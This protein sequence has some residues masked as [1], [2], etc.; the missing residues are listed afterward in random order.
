MKRFPL[1]TAMLGLTVLLTACPQPA[2]PEAT[3]SLSVVLS[4][5][6]NAPVRITNTTSG[7]V[8]FDGAL[9]SGKN[10]TGLAKGAVLKVDPGSVNGFTT[11]AAQTVTLDASKTVTLDYKALAGTAVQQNRIQGAVSDLP[12]GSAISVLSQGSEV[13]T[14]NQSAV[15]GGALGLSLS[16]APSVPLGPLMPTGTTGYCRFTGTGSVN[17]NVALFS[18][19]SLLSSKLDYLGTVTETLVA[20]GTVSG[21]QVA[22]LYSDRAATVQGTVNCQFPDGVTLKVDI[23]LTLTAGWNAVEYA[24]GQEQLTLRT[25]GSGARSVLKATRSPGEVSVSLAGPVE[26]TSDAD[27]AVA[28]SIYQDGGYTGQISLSTDVPGLTIEPGTVTLTAATLSSQGV[29][30]AAYLRHLGLHPQRLDTTLTFRY[31]GESNLNLAPFQ[32]VARDTAGKQVGNGYGTVS[33]TRPGLSVMLCPPN[34]QMFPSGTLELSVCASSVG[35]YTGAVTYTVAGLPAGLSAAPV[36]TTLNGASYVTL[37][38]TGDGTVKPGTYPITVTGTSADKSASAAGE[39]TVRAPTVNLS[40]SGYEFSVSQGETAS[41]PVMVSTSNGFSGPTTVT[42]TDLPAGVTTTPKTVTVTPGGSTQVM[43]PVQASASAALG[44]TT[45]KVTSPNLDPFTSPTATLSVRPA[46]AALPVQGPVRRLAQASSGAWITTDGA[47]DSATGQY[48]YQVTR[49]SAS[50]QALTSASAPGSTSMRLISTGGGV[51]AVS[52]DGPVVAT[53]VSD[54]GAITI[55]PTPQLGGVAAM[56]PS[57]DSQGRVWF[58]RRTDNAGAA[59]Y[60]MNTWTPATGAVTPVTLSLAGVSSFYGNQN[61][62]FSPNRQQLVFIAPGYPGLIYR[63]D[64]ATQQAT[65]VDTTVQASSAAISDNGALWLSAYNTLSRVNADGTVTQFDGVSTGQL[66]GFDLSS[67]TTLWGQDTSGVYRVDVS[68]A[69]PTSTFIS[70]GNVTGSAL[71]ASGGL[72][73]VWSEN[74]TGASS[75]SL[76]K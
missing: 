39:L 62:F 23:D 37:K 27:V 60:S 54:A 1:P 3:M 53:L 8:L 22:R 72:L 12:A 9:E 47:F 43:V 21:S 41:I 52:T 71:N 49:V 25:L 69:K 17:P 59:T 30:T 20:G 28:A 24:A 36:T 15:S 44:N 56:S 33:V 4:G 51:L 40:F 13:D 6:N 16:R 76:V 55:L 65:K 66:T 67:S 48:Q 75:I 68:V 58:V 11:P 19:V 61:F 31:S 14:N 64:T 74:Y 7:T 34:A 35:G 45:I 32:I 70:L 10:F 50:G 73:T 2:T 29:Q 18:R 46:R 38:V 5:V 57:T 63:I 42:L 26:F